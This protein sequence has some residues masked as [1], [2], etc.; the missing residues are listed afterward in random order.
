MTDYALYYSDDGWSQA[1]DLGSTT[2]A[3]MQEY[4]QAHPLRYNWPGYKEFTYNP[5]TAG[6]IQKSTDIS[7][8]EAQNI[9]GN[10]WSSSSSG[11]S[12]G[13]DWFTGQS[14]RAYLNPT[15]TGALYRIKLAP[16]F[17]GDWFGEITLTFYIYVARGLFDITWDGNG[18]TFGTSGDT[19][20][21]QT[22]IYPASVTGDVP[23]NQ[24]NWSGHDFV[25]W[26]TLPSGGA[27]VTLPFTA[28]MDRTIYARWT[29]ST[30]RT[31]SLVYHMNGGTPQIPTQTANTPSSVSTYTFT[32][33]SIRPTKSGYV[34]AG[35]ALVESA[36]VASK[37]P[38][39]TVSAA[40][41][42]G[43]IRDLYAV[44]QPES[45]RTFTL[46]YNMRGATTQYETQT[47]TGTSS[48]TSHT[49]TIDSRTPE[50]AGYTFLGWSK[51]STATTASYHPGDSIGVSWA[52]DSGYVILYAIWQQSGG[53]E[54]VEITLYTNTSYNSTITHEGGIRL[55]SSPAYIPG[56]S[57]R[58]ITLTNRNG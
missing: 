9:L 20:L 34:F 29:G 18:G 38:G 27:S 25:G 11:G 36:T 40:W 21:T 37:Q 19:T 41:R 32:I 52:I 24:V 17:S 4:A 50:K 23:T 44:W 2:D 33:S 1:Y 48:T 46:E 6:L 10:Y 42:D 54:V 15:S 35:W 22:Y 51:S 31:F 14:V 26:Y 28:T 16:M 8:C 13:N 57:Q 55:V 45:A 3:Q 53:G 47:Y 5:V 43:G 7:V 30:E 12:S 58:E 56:S 49:F 39:D